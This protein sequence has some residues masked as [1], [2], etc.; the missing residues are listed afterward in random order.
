[1]KIKKFN[2]IQF[3]KEFD[4]EVYKR[5]QELVDKQQRE[6]GGLIIIDESGVQVALDF[7]YKIRRLSSLTDLDKK[8]Y[9]DAFSNKNIVPYVIIVDG[10]TT[11][12]IYYYMQSWDRAKKA[13]IQIPILI[14]ESTQAKGLDIKNEYTKLIND[15]DLKTLDLGV[16]DDVSDTDISNIKQTYKDSVIRVV[17]GH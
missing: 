1:M 11:N 8:V 17:D 10:Y 2:E 14:F 13:K 4:K 16:V 9:R 6:R 7:G 5:F 3:N 15:P 12:Q